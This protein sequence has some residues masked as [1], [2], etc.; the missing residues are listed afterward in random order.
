MGIH[1]LFYIYPIYS[2]K[3]ANLNKSIQFVIFQLIISSSRDVPK[4]CV[5]GDA[6]YELNNNKFNG[7]LWNA[8][9]K[10]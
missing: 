8:P 9:K 3:W 10:V 4:D 7:L 6:Y 2:S 5:P 1:A